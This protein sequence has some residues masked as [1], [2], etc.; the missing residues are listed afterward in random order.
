MAIE[1]TTR[2]E[3]FLIVVKAD[4][5]LKAAAAYDLETISDGDLVITT[6]E[7]PA[8]EIQSGE[9]ASVFPDR[10]ALLATIG[11]REVEGAA[12]MAALAEQH[13]KTLADLREDHAAAIDVLQ[14][15]LSE[16]LSKS[17]TQSDSV[18]MAQARVALLRAGLIDAVTATVAA[19]GGEAQ[20]AWEYS[21]TVG[22][23]SLLV[24][25]LSA[26]LGLTTQQVDDLFRAAALI[27]F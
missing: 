9:L 17:R 2:I 26:A 22:R 13:A 4:G 1:K 24:T 15:K 18:T 6:R 12:A 20:V 7:L 14:T 5:T 11:N 19:A 16:A 23:N 8:R 27:E 21:A 10:A 3:R 25:T